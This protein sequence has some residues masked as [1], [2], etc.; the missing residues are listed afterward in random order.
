MRLLFAFCCLLTTL[1]VAQP[2]AP[3]TWSCQSPTDLRRCEESTDPS[4]VA[5]RQRSCVSQGS[6]FLEA[7]C[8]SERRLGSC[9]TSPG[10][11][12]HFSALP[13]TRGGAALD[14]ARARKGCLELKG[15]FVAAP[16]SEFTEAMVAYLQ[17]AGFSCEQLASQG[18]CT[19]FSIFTT[20]ELLAAQKKACTFTG[21]WRAGPC[22]TSAD[23]LGRCDRPRAHEPV[24]YYRGGPK[25][26]DAQSAQAACA[27]LETVGTGAEKRGGEFVPGAAPKP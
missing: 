17:R 18:T 2:A 20:P 14:E 1:A 16:T 25:K 26:L 11:T 23:L 24:F 7:P 12:T 3:K 5:S 6:L 21:T 19:E 10:V 8:P 22:P 9:R 13:N 27:T 15:E 4:M